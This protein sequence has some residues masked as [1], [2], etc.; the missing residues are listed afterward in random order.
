MHALAQYPGRG[1]SVVDADVET[2]GSPLVLTVPA[3]GPLVL[4]VLVVEGRVGSLVV[5]GSVLSSP[6]A[7]STATFGPQALATRSKPA[8]RYDERVTARA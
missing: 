1:P 7:S 2:V 5:P 8:I 6:P 3:E 4:V